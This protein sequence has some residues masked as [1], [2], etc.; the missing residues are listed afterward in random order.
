MDRTNNSL[1][2]MWAALV[3]II[4]V[5]TGLAGL[6]NLLPS[7]VGEETGNPL[8]VTNTIHDI[9]HIGTGALALFV[10]FGLKG[11]D[12][13][14][15]LIGFG[16]LYG[17]IGIAT[18]LSPDLFGLFGGNEANLP[19]HAIH[20]VASLGSIAIGYLARNDAGERTVVTR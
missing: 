9:V 3:G 15:G 10:A 8:L 4:L 12:Q 5:I 18:L 16:I 1:V 14:N 7:L 2:T 11:R 13:A 6:I 19:L 20:A 17:I